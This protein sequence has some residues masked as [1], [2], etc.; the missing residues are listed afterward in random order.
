MQDLC[1]FSQG[2][3]SPKALYFS[4]F[5]SMAVYRR[6]FSTLSPLH[7]PLATHQVVLLQAT[8]PTDTEI[9]IELL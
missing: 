6:M 1:T 4:F 2:G 3:S 8:A 7:F 9:L 5:P